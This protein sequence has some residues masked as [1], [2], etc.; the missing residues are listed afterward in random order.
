MKI[1]L[2]MS[3]Y[4]DGGLDSFN[5]IKKELLDKNDVD[6]FIHTWDKK[7]ESNIKNMYGDWIKDIQVQEQYDFKKE[8]E[9]LEGDWSNAP[10]K[11]L[12]VLSSAYG[13][14]QSILIKSEY[15]LLNNFE[16]DWVIYCRFDLGIRDKHAKPKY[17]CCEIK[18]DSKFDNQY[19]YSKYWMQL[20]QGFGDMWFYSNSENMNIFATYYDRIFDYMKLDS[21]YIKESTTSW[22]DSN[23]DEEFSNEIF[24]KN[25]SD[26]NTKFP[27]NWTLGNNHMMYKWFLIETGIY[28]NKLRFPL[29]T[30]KYIFD[31][32]DQEIY[33]F[34]LLGE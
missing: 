27:L 13:R 14:K 3:G 18:F 22:P 1:A 12:N 10:T 31:E 21:N 15:E 28:P 16:Y 26:K 5:Y 7:N 24:R 32:L 9:L 30:E 19:M 4:L 33:K 8:I 11:K 34:D 29:D 2:C 6:I 17:R 20:N 23:I 25:K